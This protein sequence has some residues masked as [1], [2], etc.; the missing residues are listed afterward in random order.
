MTIPRHDPRVLAAIAK[1]TVQ[2]KCSHLAVWLTHFGAAYQG[3]AAMMAHYKT[4]ADWLEICLKA[5]GADGK[6]KTI[7]AS[8]ERRAQDEI[9][10][11][12]RVRISIIGSFPQ[13]PA[14]WAS[15]FVYHDAVIWDVVCCWS[16]GQRQCWTNLGLAIEALAR[17]LLAKSANPDDAERRGR[18]LYERAM[19]V[20]GWI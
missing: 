10:T 13:T 12:E 11:I 2:I 6:R 7:A 4:V 3:D 14:A 17:A 18:E 8:V 16:D 5:C 15:L 20:V 9:Q 1:G 19:E